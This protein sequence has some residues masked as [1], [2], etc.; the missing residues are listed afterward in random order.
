[1]V[2]LD[3]EAGEGE[4]LAGGLPVFFYEGSQFGPSV[5]GGAADAGAGGDVVEGDRCAAGGELSAGLLDAES[6]VAAHADA[7]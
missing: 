4:R 2:D 7:A 5:E 1:L 3:G 6:Q